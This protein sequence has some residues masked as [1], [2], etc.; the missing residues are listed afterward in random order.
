MPRQPPCCCCFVVVVV[1][2]AAVAI[3]AAPFLLVVVI[4]AVVAADS[5][6]VV[7]VVVIVVKQTSHRDEINECFFSTSG[8]FS[9]ASNHYGG[10]VIIDTQLQV[11]YIA[12]GSQLVRWIRYNFLK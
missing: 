1:V 2:A 7:V 9:I 8:I 3:D 12:R 10:T 11:P 5:V 6:V 4:V